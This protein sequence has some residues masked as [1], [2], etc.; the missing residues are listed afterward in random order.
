MKLKSIINTAAVICVIAII[1]AGI[2]GFNVKGKISAAENRKLASFPDKNPFHESFPKQMDTYI[3]DRIGMREPAVKAYGYIADYLP[4]N[5]TGNTAIEGEN[6]W[7]FLNQESDT[8]C[9][10]QRTSPFSEKSV[11]KILGII[12][13]NVKFCEEHGIKLVLIIP[14][15]K[16]T[17]YPEYYPKYIKHLDKPVPYETLVQRIKTSADLPLVAPLNV[18]LSGKKEQEL[19][20]RK[21]SHWNTFGSY[22]AYRILAEEIRKIY[23]DFYILQDKDME[24]CEVEPMRDLSLMLKLP[25]GDEPKE[26]GLC[27]PYQTNLALKNEPGIKRSDYAAGGDERGPKI[28]LIHDSFMT[29]LHP[30][31]ERSASEI[32][33]LWV[34]QYD[35][36]KM[37]DIIL[38][39]K[40][41]II[42]WEVLE[43]YFAMQ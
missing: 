10:Y 20:F 11:Q 23:P 1:A 6:G 15:N 7:L 12:N 18:L 39:N 29:A 3:N 21:D 9:Y 17:V 16:S 5:L 38:E 4:V 36:E 40:P 32:A 24:D 33:S 37:K 41:D 26:K 27:P 43:R 2:I 35:F 25:Y 22:A 13:A 8:Y 34:Y 31:L 14:P 30:Y 19:Y 42:I 28:L